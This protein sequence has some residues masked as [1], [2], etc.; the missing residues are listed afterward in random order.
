MP[1][2]EI[3]P[4]PHWKPANWR[5]KILHLILPE[6]L[7]ENAQRLNRKEQAVEDLIK[8]KEL[9]Q[10]GQLELTGHSKI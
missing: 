1:F 6:T 10:L 3:I 5:T 8:A 4:I 7:Q 9:G 2:S